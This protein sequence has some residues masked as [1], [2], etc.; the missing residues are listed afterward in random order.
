MRCDWNLAKTEFGIFLEYFRRDAVGIWLRHNLELS[1]NS[2]DNMQLELSYD[3]IW[4]CHRKFSMRC[5]WNFAKTQLRTVVE[6][7]Q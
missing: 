6:Q 7:F 1:Q 5:D 3:I 2:F 4:K